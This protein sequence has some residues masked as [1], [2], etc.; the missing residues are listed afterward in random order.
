MDRI[1]PILP[2]VNAMLIFSSGLF[3]LSGVRAIRRGEREVHRLRMLTATGLASLF[4]VIYVTRVALGGLT[5]FPGPYFVKVL[6]LTI[7][8]SHLTVAILSLPLIL[9][10]IYRALTANYPAHKRL[11]RFAYPMW[12]FVSFTGVLVYVLLHLPYQSF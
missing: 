4:L 9:T 8:F 5:T 10:T 12:V 7:L 6:Y 1:L 3:I 2:A 11:A